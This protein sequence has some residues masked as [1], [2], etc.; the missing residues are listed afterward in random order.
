MSLSIPLEPSSRTKLGFESSP[1]KCNPTPLVISFQKFPTTHWNTRWKLALIGD[2]KYCSCEGACRMVL[3][4][5]IGHHVQE[6]QEVTDLWSVVCRLQLG[7][8][9]EGHLHKFAT[10]WHMWDSDIFECKKMLCMLCAGFCRW[11]PGGA[12]LFQC[13]CPCLRR[14]DAPSPATGGATGGG[15]CSGSGCH[16]QQRRL[17]FVSLVYQVFRYLSQRDIRRM[18]LH[19]LVSVTQGKCVQSGGEVGR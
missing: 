18:L 1:G 11:R 8:G 9:A 15:F 6:F 3:K 7:E 13:L 2:T 14:T 16:W 10:R 12:V 17:V 5:E 19:V 4:W